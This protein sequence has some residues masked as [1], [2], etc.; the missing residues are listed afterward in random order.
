[1]TGELFDDRLTKLE[2][3][4]RRPGTPAEG[5]AAASAIARILGA[6]LPGPPYRIGDRVYA[7]LTRYPPCRHCGSTLFKIARGAGPHA[8]E[9]KCGACGRHSK[10]LRRAL[11]AESAT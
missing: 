9:L 6:R 7:G 10:W 3:L 8:A 2:A 1:M 4:A 5:H 11:I